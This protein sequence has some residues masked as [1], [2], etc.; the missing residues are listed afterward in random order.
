MFATMS[1]EEKQFLEALQHDKVQ[2][3]QEMQVQMLVLKDGGTTC[4]AGGY[5]KGRRYE[6]GKGDMVKDILDKRIFRR[7][8]DSVEQQPNLNPGFLTY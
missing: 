4:A 6:G 5:G 2:M 3:M 8:Q 1:V 7:C